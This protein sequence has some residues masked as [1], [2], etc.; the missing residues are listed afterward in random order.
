MLERISKRLK[1]GS[2]LIN[3]KVDSFLH[4][5]G[6]GREEISWLEMTARLVSGET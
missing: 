1:I 6:A 5:N 3:G 2:W 4:E